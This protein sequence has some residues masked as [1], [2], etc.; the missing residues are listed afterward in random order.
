MEKKTPKSVHSKLNMRRVLQIK[1]NKGAYIKAT[2][3]SG[4][5]IK[6]REIHGCMHFRQSPVQFVWQ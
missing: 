2:L 3:Q 4:G 5:G 6:E 1:E